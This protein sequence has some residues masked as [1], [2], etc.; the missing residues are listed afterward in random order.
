MDTTKADLKLLIFEEIGSKADDLQEEA[1]REIYRAQGA[2]KAL[3]AATQNIGGLI[4]LIQDEI[5]KGK[6]DLE[7]G[8]KVVG[9]VARAG[10]IVEDLGRH[11][12][13]QVQLNQGRQ[14]GL[15]DAVNLIRS[16]HDAEE[17]KKVQK[18]AQAELEEQDRKD[19]A[20]VK[21]EKAAEPPKPAEPL[22]EPKPAPKKPR[23]KRVT[24]KKEPAKKPTEEKPVSKR[25]RI[26]SGA[27]NS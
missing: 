3:K 15:M 17:K 5:D 23:K 22:P 13:N 14:H 27:D 10:S 19:D 1:E 12:L 8:K 16:M 25:K 9:A 6:L 11:Y 4:K 2:V 21:A 24:K 26:R 18:A 7:E 20:A